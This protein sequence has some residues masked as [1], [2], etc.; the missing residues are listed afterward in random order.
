M[1][2]TEVIQKFKLSGDAKCQNAIL[3]Q[4]KK[5]K[6]REDQNALQILILHVESF[7]LS[8]HTPQ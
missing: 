1:N 5:K 2:N 4:K 8:Y 6:M 3:P 7:H